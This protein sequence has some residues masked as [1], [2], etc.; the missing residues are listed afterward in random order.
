MANKLV[1]ST[2]IIAT[3][4]LT[5]SLAL[6]MVPGGPANG[7]LTNISI[8]KVD[9]WSY[10]G[11]STIMESVKAIATGG[12]MMRQFGSVGA[13]FGSLSASAKDIGFSVGGAKDINNFRENIK[14]GFLPIATDVT[15]EGLF[16]DYNFDN[17]GSGN[18]VCTDMFCPVYSQVVSKDPLT[19]ATDRFL[20]VGLDSGIQNFDRKPLDLMI[21]LDI[22]GSMGSPF[23]RYYYDQFGQPGQKPGDNKEPTQ[24]EKE[25][26]QK[27]KIKVAS[28]SIVALLDHLRD[29]DKVGMVLF[30]T[31]AVLAKPMNLVKGT[32]MDDIK[33]HVMELQATDSTNME[34]GYKL[35][36]A[37]FDDE[38][39]DKDGSAASDRERRIIFLTDA[40]PNTGDFSKEGLVG[41]TKD[42]AEKGIHTTF[43]GMG[44]D[45][46]TALIETMTKIRGA[47]YYSVH[48]SKE[49][50]TR[51]DEQFDFMV[52]PLVYNLKMTLKSSDYSIDEV[53]GSPEAD[54]ATGELMSVNTL[55]PSP[56]SAEG[57]KG[58]IILLKLKKIGAGSDISLSVDYET[59]DGQKH[60]STK[61]FVFEDKQP[62]YFGTNSDRKAVL[63]TRYAS[64][65]KDWLDHETRNEAGWGEYQNHSQWERQSS[66]LHVA[67]EYRQRFKTFA[68][69]FNKEKQDIGDD[70]LKKEVDV[71]T[72]LSS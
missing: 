51:M 40:Q 72:K 39:D 61:T 63:L 57:V 4:L 71:L 8:I 66:P 29:D 45:F 18:T 56:K 69:Y 60:S 11:Q 21:V 33:R 46:N 62:E 2:A 44:V 47:N 14:Q 65:I 55:F 34:A 22:S 49:F 3:L 50:K 10:S 17:S 12:G 53:Y 31:D 25:E 67:D 20:S 23:D 70:S 41:I 37:Q 5:V 64:L 15:Y 48:D 54:Q 24:E 9:D 42:N 6:L 19:N 58:G 26:L 27:S 30:S 16:Y 59:R 28:E 32:N 38:L 36:T 68:E 52:F 1:V 35:A 43:V 13:S 7:W